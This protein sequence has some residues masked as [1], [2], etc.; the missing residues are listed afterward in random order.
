MSSAKA[1]LLI[2]F[3]LPLLVLSESLHNPDPYPQKV[4]SNQAY[5]ALH[6]TP[7]ESLSSLKESEYTVL[8]HPTFPRYSLRIKKTRFCDSTVKYVSVADVYILRY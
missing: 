7:L 5:D 8:S 4:L 2:V 1:F 3:L 6:I